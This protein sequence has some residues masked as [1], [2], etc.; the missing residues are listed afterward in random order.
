[1]AL[2]SETDIPCSHTARASVGSRTRDALGRPSVVCQERD[3]AAM[4]LWRSMNLANIVPA[5]LGE[6]GDP[7]DIL[8]LMILQSYQIRD[9]RSARSRAKQSEDWQRNDRLIAVTA[10]AQTHHPFQKQAIAAPGKHEWSAGG[11]F[12]P[13][14]WSSGIGHACRG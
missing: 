2:R 13:N 1:M 8:V 12:V 10:H 4:R 5:T 14:I 7:L 6:D 3:R 9:G 11:C